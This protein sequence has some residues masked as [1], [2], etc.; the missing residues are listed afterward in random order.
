MSRKLEDLIPIL[1]IKVMELSKNAKD[2][3]INILI[4]DTW[5]SFAEQQAIYDQGRTK[6][7]NI[8]TWAKPGE[9]YHNYGL[10]FDFVPMSSSGKPDWNATDKFHIVGELGED[11]LLEWGGRWIKKDMPHFQMSFGFKLVELI[12]FYQEGGIKEVWK[13]CNDKYEEGFWP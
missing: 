1:A 6:P 10:A 2:K 3:G 5:R 7:G 12:Q 11:I 13:W 4:T 8:V 9:S